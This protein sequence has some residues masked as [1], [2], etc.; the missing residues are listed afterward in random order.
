MK[1]RDEKQRKDISG[2]FFPRPKRKVDDEPP[3]RVE[4][5]RGGFGEFE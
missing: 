2:Q 3:R 5:E 4:Y 1:G